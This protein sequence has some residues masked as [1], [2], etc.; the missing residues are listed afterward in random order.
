VILSVDCRVFH[1]WARIFICLLTRVFKES[2]CHDVLLDFTED[3]VVIVPH[4]LISM[5]HG[6]VFTTH[7]EDEGSSE[8]AC[9][10]IQF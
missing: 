7:L 3:R 2:V 9:T 10:P 8:D 6:L 4:E 1:V 5:I